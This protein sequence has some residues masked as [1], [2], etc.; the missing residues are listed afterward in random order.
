MLLPLPNLGAAITWTTRRCS[1]DRCNEAS[2]AAAERSGSGLAVAVVRAPATHMLR[3][4]ARIYI[5][6]AGLGHAGPDLDKKVD[7]ARAAL[8]QLAGAK[9][10]LSR[11]LF[12]GAD[13][14]TA[15]GM[16]RR[17]G[18]SLRM[19]QHAIYCTTAMML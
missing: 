10:L 7:C 3:L 9:V 8:V 2:R 6:G 4:T 11:R 16:R 19:R 14:A 5:R 15:L 1:Q 13:T 18:C 17:R 12:L